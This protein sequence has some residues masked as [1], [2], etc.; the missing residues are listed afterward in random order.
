MRTLKSIKN[1]KRLQQLHQLIENE[2]TGSPRELAGK[3]RISERSVYKLIDY[4][5]DYSANINYDRSRKTYY[6]NSDFQ[7]NVNISVSIVCNNETTEVFG[8][9]Y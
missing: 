7:I 9:S 5:K 3:M 1:L 4:L 6:Y 2:R 8:G